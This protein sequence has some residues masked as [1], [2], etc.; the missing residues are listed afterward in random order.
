MKIRRTYFLWAFLCLVASFSG[1]VKEETVSEE[2]VAQKTYI[3]FEPKVV[4]RYWQEVPNETRAGDSTYTANG[5]SYVSAVPNYASIFSATKVEST[6]GKGM[7]YSDTQDAGK[8]NAS[9]SNTVTRAVPVT[10]DSFHSTMGVYGYYG[11]TD[12]DNSG[13][14][15]F[16]DL[17]CDASSSW[18]T[19][20][21]YPA[22]GSKFHFCAYAPYGADGLSIST[23]TG[24]AIGTYTVPSDVANQNDLV[25]AS[26]ES[27][28]TDGTIPLSFQHVLTGIRFVIGDTLTVGTIKSISLKNIYSSG[29]VSLETGVWS[30]V[31]TQVTFSQTLD[32]GIGTS[33]DEITT[34]SQT[35]MMIP[36][37]LP[38][39]ATIEVVYANV[40]GIESTLTFPLSGTVWESGTIVTYNVSHVVLPDGTSTDYVPIETDIVTI[41]DTGYPA[42]V[43][44]DVRINFM[45]G[46]DVSNV[47]LVHLTMG[48][49]K[50]IV[51]HTGNDASIRAGYICKSLGTG[52]R[53]L[54]LGGVKINTDYDFSLG[55]YKNFHITNNVSGY[56]ST[57]NRLSSVYY[58]GDNITFGS[59]SA[60]AMSKVYSFKIYESGVLVRNFVPYLSTDGTTY[61][62]FDTITGISIYAS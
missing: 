45:T 33:G 44:T 31:S 49:G 52:Y 41:F 59:F 20:L 5:K 56:S 14:N 51:I 16:E 46:S 61:F 40:L 26:S 28:S 34:A 21:Q 13:Y 36:Q 9:L 7:L 37:T 54:K 62:F 1:C 8:I 38:S 30:S 12:W 60:N 43:N 29:I 4:S 42:T 24:E 27:S 15:F 23:T 48:S 32:K 11:T 58:S 6:D 35:F 3:S 10:T 2:K 19:G 55:N 53:S 25:I 22:I 50:Y 47:N 39:D 18:S 17:E 57:S